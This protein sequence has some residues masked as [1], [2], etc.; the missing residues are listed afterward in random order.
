M[1]PDPLRLSDAR[2]PASVAW[3]DAANTADQFS[4]FLNR[5]QVHLACIVSQCLRVKRA[6]GQSPTCR[7]FLPR[8]LLPE[9]VVTKDINHKGWLFSPARNHAYPNQCA[10]IINV[11]WM[12]NTDIQPLTT[13]RA[14][15]SCVGKYV[16][17]PEKSSESYSQLQTQILPYINDRSPLLSFTSRMLNKLIGERDW[18][19]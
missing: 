15:L 14:V 10:P 2:N 16:S 4:A 6:L 8:P 7:F 9:A 12:A 1:N 11:S 5:L 19:A 17:K 3:A 13:L 18:S